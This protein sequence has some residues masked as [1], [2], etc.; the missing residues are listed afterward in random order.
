MKIIPS[1]HFALLLAA[2]VTGFWACEHDAPIPAAAP[3]A[4]AL[5]LSALPDTCFE[6]PNGPTGPI[7]P[8]IVD[9]TYFAVSASSTEEGA[10][11]YVREDYVP[12]SAYGNQKIFKHNICTGETTLIYEIVGGS[13]YLSING[14][15]EILFHRRPSQS[16]LLASATIQPPIEV[17]P[18]GEYINP[19]WINNDSFNISR[20]TGSGSNFKSLMVD[21]MG[22]ETVVDPD[23]FQHVYFDALDNKLILSFQSVSRSIHKGHL[24]LYDLATQELT[25]VEDIATNY[26]LQD[27]NV[28]VFWLNATTI[29]G[30]SW[31]FVFKYNLTTREM[32]ML[33]SDDCDNTV[34][35]AYATRLKGR[36]DIVLLSRGDYLYLSPTPSQFRRRHRISVLDVNTGEEQILELE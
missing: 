36:D 15:G 7:I 3:C 30:Y 25:L 29:I 14:E 22:N 16:I 26:N 35:F 2:A 6:L 11:Y 19:R 34:Y 10:F 32:T 27:V 33:H 28:V 12:S 17:M 9:Y 4:I 13:F 24:G 21:Q 18:A 31:G 20:W 23:I 1:T 8:P 5:P